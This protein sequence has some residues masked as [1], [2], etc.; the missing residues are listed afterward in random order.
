MTLQSGS[1]LGAYEIL[2]PIGAGEMGEVYKARDTKLGREVAI[3]VLPEVFS[4]D[5]ERLFRFER[6][7]R[8]LASL[9]H[10][11]IAT[12]YDIEES[13]GT[14]FLALEFVP[15]EALA[16]QIKQGPVAIDEAI[17]I[18]KQ[19]AE[20]LE[21][22]HEKGIIH[23]DLKPANIKV[24]PEGTVKVLDFG[25]AKA[26]LGDEPPTDSSQ[27]PTLTRGTA[28]GAIMGTAAY[29]SPEQARG[30]PVDRRTDIWAFGCVSYEV[31]TGTP[32]F[33]GETI[34]DILTGVIH[35]EP[36]WNVL[37]VNTPW[38]VREIIK[39]CLRKNARD[40]LQHMGDA[41]VE[42]EMD[43]KEPS[44]ESPPALPEHAPFV[45]RIWK[46]APW[47]LVV[48]IGV[49][50]LWE[51]TGEFPLSRSSAQLAVVLPDGYSL[52][53]ASINPP[54]PPLLMAA[55]W[56]SSPPTKRGAVN[57]IFGRSTAS[58]RHLFP[59]LEERDIPSSR[60]MAN[61]W[62]F[63]RAGVSGRSCSQEAPRS[64]SLTCLHPAL[65]LVPG[66]KPA[67]NFWLV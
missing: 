16:E 59:I 11:N 8:L 19:I 10:P 40:R 29:M 28:L 32:A 15:G 60:P 3:K 26:L 64:M 4:Q 25:L 24:T 56:R 36:D 17:P 61:G 22:A 21:A 23:R 66:G 7:A 9:N 45:T 58:R 63:S 49:F 48:L 35:R 33:D 38:R 12:I 18:F 37:P 14:H 44:V 1:R 57:S 5:K 31:L 51:R 50:S 2:S 20:A 62:V 52:S 30:K 6:E 27:S 13:E 41:R 54:S 42:L 65:S 67:T 46:L 39:K 43:M 34:T 47:T 55:A 53:L